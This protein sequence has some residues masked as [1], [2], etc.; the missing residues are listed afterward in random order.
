MFGLREITFN[1]WVNSPLMTIKEPLKVRGC[2][3][4]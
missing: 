3:N 1:S 2:M 4:L